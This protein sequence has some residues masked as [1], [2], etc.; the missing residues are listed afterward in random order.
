MTET[1]YWIAAS[2]ILLTTIGLL[3]SHDW[4]WSL[5]ILAIQYLGS[6]W[7]VHSNWSISMAAVK[8]VAGWMV[9]AILG[10]AIFSSHEH[11]TSETSWP[12]GWL[13][14]FLVGSLIALITFPL[15]QNAATWLNLN[16]ALAW[17]SLLLMGMGL[18]QL[19]ITSR[20]LR[21]IIGLLT[22]LSGFEI[23]YSAV[24]S[25]SLIAALL[26]VVNLCLALAGA[27]LLNV[28]VGEISK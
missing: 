9:C 18:L 23:I 26:A 8:L 2:L 6:F 7:L 19:G 11:P 3:L 13:F 20:P 25:S 27:Y 4:R 28:N 14:R 12:Q 21:V 24:E 15:A 17:G 1:L 16:P 22:F 10:S 5:G